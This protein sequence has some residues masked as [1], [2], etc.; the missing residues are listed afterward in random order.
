MSA[1]TALQID[2]LRTLAKAYRDRAAFAETS[3]ARAEEL[4]EAIRIEQRIASLTPSQMQR[5]IRGVALCQCCGELADDCRAERAAKA[6]PST[7][8]EMVAATRRIFEGKTREQVR[9]AVPEII[10]AI[11]AIWGDRCDTRT[12]EYI[13]QP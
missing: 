9:A 6:S 7:T 5:A 11:R 12:P 1:S 4:N 10:A 2:E 8:A 13:D 3:S